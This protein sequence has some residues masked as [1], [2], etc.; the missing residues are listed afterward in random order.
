ME[1]LEVKQIQAWDAYTIQNE[2]IE[3]IGLM[4][5]ASR[6]FCS[7]F[8]E[9][10][11]PGT[12]Q[13]SV[14][15]SL[16]N[17]GGDGLAISR[18]LSDYGMDV[19]IFLCRIQPQASEDFTINLER[20]RYKNV[21]I[22]E[23]AEG[24]AFPSFREAEVLIDGLFGS[25]L[26]RPVEGFWATFIEHINASGKPVF[27]IDMPSGMFCDRV[28]PPG[29]AV[30][31][32]H[33]CLSFERPKLGFLFPAHS[34]WLRA[35][36]YR[37]IG[38][39]PDFLAT[40]SCTF[41]YITSELAASLL[42]DRAIFSHK[43]NYGRALLVGG[44]RGM[45]GA[46]VLAARAA[47]RSG[48]GLVY[49]LVPDCGLDILQMCVPESI[50]LSGC[51]EQHL[52]RV[53]A[54]D[55]YDAIGLGPGLGTE[56]ETG[57]F[58]AQCLS[59]TTAPLVLDADALNLLAKDK[60]LFRRIPKNSILTPHPGEFGRLFGILSDDRLRIDRL[61]ELAKS[62]ELFIVLKGAY[63]AIGM[64]DGQVWFNSTGNPGMATGGSGDVLTGMLT[65]LLAQGYSPR[66]ACLLG[67][68]L[69]GLA[70]DLGAEHHGEE[71]LSAGDI[72]AFI[73]EAFRKLKKNRKKYA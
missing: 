44:Q 56:P 53:P 12:Q 34:P 23:L 4:E 63:T 27:S 19:R 52:T 68:H 13:V 48:A 58:L 36:D 9:K 2:P 67:V 47:L 26:S 61:R 62:M 73:G 41:H 35:W 40:I 28:T 8:L 66:A 51:G 5:R 20:L 42:E 60:T 21:G 1:I 7:W 18:M 25:G 3:S 30:I 24:S 14:L 57:D 43:G 10:M 71:A 16:G 50:V 29:A 65:G 11:P 59:Q 33:F 39:H 22:T 6:V 54:L 32:A 38:L 69:H 37:S 55:A 49:S 64:P 31:K 46:S 17:N 15:V 70:G 72:V 45:M